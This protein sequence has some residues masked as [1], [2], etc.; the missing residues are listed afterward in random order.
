MEN[1]EVEQKVGIEDDSIHKEE[2]RISGPNAIK[3][4]LSLGDDLINNG[5]FFFKSADVCSDMVFL[6]LVQFKTL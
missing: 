5:A 1:K 4:K 6:E 3:S 2:G